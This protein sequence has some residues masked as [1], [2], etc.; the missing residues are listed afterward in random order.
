MSERVMHGSIQDR[1]DFYQSPD[2]RWDQI[3][4]DTIRYTVLQ[5]I[6][7]KRWLKKQKIQ[8]AKR[9]KPTAVAA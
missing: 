5:T 4:D 2:L 1:T 9:S 3:L 7:E 8:V 6:E